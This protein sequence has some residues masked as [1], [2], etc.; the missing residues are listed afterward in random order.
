MNIISDVPV[1]Y[2]PTQRRYNW[3]KICSV[4]PI[5]ECL[6]ASYDSIAVIRVTNHPCKRL[7]VGVEIHVGMTSVE[8]Q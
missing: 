4:N 2:S 1:Q 3:H 8:L 7:K 5:R 6:N